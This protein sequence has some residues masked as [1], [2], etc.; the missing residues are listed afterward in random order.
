MRP[1]CQHSLHPITVISA[2]LR[3]GLPSSGRMQCANNK[4]FLP[5][6][7]SE[8]HGIRHLEACVRIE[9][10]SNSLGLQFASPAESLV[11]QELQKKTSKRNLGFRVIHA[12]GLLALQPEDDCGRQVS[13][14]HLP[15]AQASKQKTAPYNELHLTTSTR[16]TMVQAGARLA[17]K[18]RDLL[19]NL[20]SQDSEKSF[21]ASAILCQC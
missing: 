3:S 9:D 21:V 20:C 13:H 10:E 5:L 4:L 12:Q 2:C 7:G 6:P 11:P 19:C 18:L 16:E 8:K 17:L 1:Q 15:R 14:R